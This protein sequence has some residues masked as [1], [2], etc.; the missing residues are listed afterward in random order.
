MSNS[1]FKSVETVNTSDIQSSW[2]EA[3]R[4]WGHSLHTLAPYVGGF[5]PALARYFI[6]RFTVEGNTVLDPFCGGGTTLLEA[7]LQNRE[8]WGNDAFTYAAMLSRAKCNPIPRD[9]FKSY[10]IEKLDEATSIPKDEIGLDEDLKVFYEEETLYDIVRLKQVLR[11][12]S[13]D[14]ATFLNGIMCGILHGPS[15]MFLSVQT[16]DTYSGSVDYVRKYIEENGLEKHR[17]YIDDCAMTKYERVSTDGLPDFES[18]VVQEDA[19][20]L[21]GF[22]DRGADFILTSPPYMHVLD[23]TWNNW[24][25]LWWLNR[26]R[27]AEREQMDITA[28]VEKYR[29]FISEALE[30]MYR[31]LSTDSRAVIV[32]GDVKKHRSKGTNIVRTGRLIAEEAAEVG[33]ELNHVID[34]AYDINKRSYVRFN[35]LKYNR[36]TGNEEVTEE[37]IDRCLV[38]NK[39]TPDIDNEVEIDWEKSLEVSTESG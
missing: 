14:L 3:P 16:K 2:R 18:T 21:N 9:A 23:Y 34:D 7:G 13:G 4:G 10:L 24:I 15:P 27:G 11:G 31:V 28:D 36:D 29:S 25:R 17:R 20:T 19:R 37:L 1:T 5:P 6:E 32:I 22:P 26:D 12:E 33:F 35:D 38:L 30:S 39:G 8:A